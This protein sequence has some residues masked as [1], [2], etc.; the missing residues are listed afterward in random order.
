MADVIIDMVYI[1]SLVDAQNAKEDFLNNENVQKIFNRWSG[2][3]SPTHLACVQVM[4][5]ENGKFIGCHCLCKNEIDKHE[6]LVGVF[7]NKM[8]KI[9]KINIAEQ[10]SKSITQ[11]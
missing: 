7:N 6:D 11:F 5:D 9:Y 10:L 4:W 1:Q 3:L 8:E 2:K